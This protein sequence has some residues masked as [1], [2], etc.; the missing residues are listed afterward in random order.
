MLY[1]IEPRT[2]TDRVEAV[3]L[4]DVNYHYGENI[5]TYNDHESAESIQ[6]GTIIDCNGVNCVVTEINSMRFGRVTLTVKPAE[7]ISKT[8]TGAL[9]R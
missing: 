2:E 6:L 3:G 9:K 1:I 4:P 8:T 5:V 7:S